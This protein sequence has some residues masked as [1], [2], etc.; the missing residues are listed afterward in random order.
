MN[1]L[2]ML[3]DISHVSDSVMA[4][5]LRLSE[6]PVIF[7]HSSARALVDHKRDVPDEIL[8]MVPANGGVVMVNFYCFFTDSATLRW[9]REGD[10]ARAQLAQRYG[11]DTAQ[12]RQGM[13]AWTAAHPQPP[14]PT[15]ATIANHIDHIARVAGVDHV[16]YG[17]DFD[18]IDCAPQGL[19]DVSMFPNLTAELLR[20]GWS[21][22]DVLKVTGGNL[23]RVFRQAELVARRLQRERG[24]SDATIAMD[25]VRAGS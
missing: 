16:G 17:S 23:L 1:R 7:S 5:V 22:R 25:S 2:G 19:E 15:V 12:V 13:G 11:A 3:V 21:E 20:R 8:R 9:G 6:A 14:R 4:Q 18:G 24:P 10:A